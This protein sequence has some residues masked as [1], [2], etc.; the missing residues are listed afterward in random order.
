[1]KTRIGLMSFVALLVACRSSVAP[2]PGGVRGS[3]AFAPISGIPNGP[4]LAPEGMPCVVTATDASGAVATTKTN[5]RG[6]YELTLQPG[7]Y[8]ISF[9]ACATDCPEVFGPLPDSADVAPGQWVELSWTCVLRL[10]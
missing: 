6:E 7:H 4:A 3:A 5:E 9:G 10:K 2:S 8:E 1:M